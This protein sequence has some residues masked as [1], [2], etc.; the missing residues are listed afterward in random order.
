MVPSR[1]RRGLP[2]DEPVSH[3]VKER[4]ELRSLRYGGHLLQ[5]DAGDIEQS[6]L[7]SAGHVQNHH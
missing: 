2:I 4:L 1:V 6:N 3:L 5:G 7:S